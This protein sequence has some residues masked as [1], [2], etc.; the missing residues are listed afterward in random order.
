MKN[1]E[2]L[3][4]VNPLKKHIAI[5]DSRRKFKINIGVRKNEVE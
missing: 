2:V 1:K 3:T 4:L 5:E